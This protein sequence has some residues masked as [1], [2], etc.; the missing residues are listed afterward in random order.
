M[1]MPIGS[2]T[3]S[4]RLRSPRLHLANLP[5]QALFELALLV[6]L[7]LL[8]MLSIIEYSRALNMEQRLVDLTRQG[9]NMASRGTALSTAAAAVAQGSAPL[10]VSS[11]GGGGITPAP[12]SS[13]SAT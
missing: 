4:I 1:T 10:N 11:A 12:R 8:V 9:S 6:P 7:L 3:R 13:N 2:A 5:G